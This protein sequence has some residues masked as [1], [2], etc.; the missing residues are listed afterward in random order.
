MSPDIIVRQQKAD[1][2]TLAQI[3][4]LTNGSLGENIQYGTSD[5]YIYFRLQNRGS[6]GSSGTFRLF[7]SPV[8]TFPTPASW[9]QVGTFNFPSISGGGFWVP[10]TNNDCITMPGTMITTLGEGHFCFIGIVETVADPAPD[11]MQISTTAEFHDFIRKSNNFAWRNC[12]IATVTPNRMGTYDPVERKFEIRGFN[13]QKQFR[14]LEV[15]T[16]DL[17]P[18][19]TI[20]VWLPAVKVMGMK[21]SEA[22]LLETLAVTKIA[23]ALLEPPVAKTPVLHP[24]AMAAPA[25]AVTAPAPAVAARAMAAAAPAAEA[26]ELRLPVY[27]L[28]RETPKALIPARIKKPELATW[29]ALTIEAGRIVR[30]HNLAMPRE[31]KIDVP[32]VVQF[33]P[34]LGYRNVTLA[35]RERETGGTLG[36]MSYVFQ[37]RPR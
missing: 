8:S 17:P 25:L 35:F 24:A 18:G 31:D 36:Q 23:D 9:T 10:P 27:E 12:D 19:T 11:R 33:P 1:A 5:H 26:A 21:A 30:L 13:R 7:I 16:R 22:R 34:N 32:F 20:A 28:V 2:A 15:D 14:D 37:L 4:D 29:R 3:Q 6:A